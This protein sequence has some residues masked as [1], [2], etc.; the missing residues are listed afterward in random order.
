MRKIIVLLMALCLLCA[1]A[2]AE[3]TQEVQTPYFTFQI[4]AELEVTAELEYEEDYAVIAEGDRYE[5]LITAG[6]YT[7]ELVELLKTANDNGEQMNNFIVLHGMY[8]E[9]AYGLD[10]FDLQE[11]DI[12]M[13]NGDKVVHGFLR[14]REGAVVICT[15]FYRDYGFMV[16]VEGVELDNA[17]GQAIV[18]AIA[19]SARHTGVTE[20]EM[21][22]DAQVDYVV[23]TADSGKIRTEASISGGLIKTAYKGETF[24]YVDEITDWY[25]IEVDGR[26]GYIHKGVSAIE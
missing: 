20:E 8:I 15:Q 11:D 9:S 24:V 10:Y 4:P 16:C 22:A 7:P 2:L 23:V 26:T 25:I 21:I 5:L 18:D 1:P 6:I 13:I 19:L 3:G 17:E 12:G 14:V